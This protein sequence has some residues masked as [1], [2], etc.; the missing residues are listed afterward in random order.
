MESDNYFQ[1]NYSNYKKKQKLFIIKLSN[2][3]QS[4]QYIE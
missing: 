3:Q 4:S 2:T 1:T